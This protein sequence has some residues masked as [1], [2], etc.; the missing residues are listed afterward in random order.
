MMTEEEESKQLLDL[1]ESS[2]G[3]KRLLPHSTASSYLD[4]LQSSYLDQVI[5]EP[6]IVTAEAARLETDITNLCYREYPLFISV[7]QC[8]TAVRNAFNDFDQSLSRLLSSVP[9]LESECKSFADNTLRLQVTR[10]KA[11]LLLEYQDKIGE[12][13]N[14]PR[15]MET[16][17]RNGFYQD[18]IDIADHAHHL[19]QD[20]GSFPLVEDLMS[21]IT[22][23]SQLMT[24]QL[25]N[26]L[27]E[28]IKLPNLMKTVG[29]I[30][31]LNIMPDADLSVVYL[32]SRLYNFER[33]IGELTPSQLDPI[34]FIRR[35]I[36]LFR[37]H[38]YDIITQFTAVFGS[39]AVLES[40][41]TTCV[42]K[43]VQVV[44]DQMPS[45]A[46]D[47]TALS[48]LLVQLG[49]CAMSFSRLGLDFS[50]YFSLPFSDQVLHS[51]KHLLAEANADLAAGFE[52]SMQSHTSLSHHILMADG[53]PAEHYDSH[54][55]EIPPHTSHI[56]PLA[57]FVNAHLS[58]LNQL[59]LLAPQHLSGKLIAIQTDHLASATANTFEFLEQAMSPTEPSRSDTNHRRSISSPRSRLVRQ[60]TET[61]LAPEQRA[62]R[63]KQSWQS[64]M[65]FGRTWLSSMQYLRHAMCHD[66]FQM[67][68]FPAF[69]ELDIF[70]QRLSE[71][72][73]E[74]S[75]SETTAEAETGLLSGS[76]SSLSA[77][78]P[79]GQA[80]SNSTP[81]E[82]YE[83]HVAST[84]EL[85]GRNGEQ[86]IGDRQSLDMPDNLTAVGRVPTP[87]LTGRNGEQSSG[88]RQSLDM[89]DNLTAAGRAPTPEL[90]GRNGEQSIGDRQSL[91]MPDNLTAVGR[92]SS[93]LADSSSHLETLDHNDDN[94]LGDAGLTEPSFE[95]LPTHEPDG[96]ESPTPDFSATD[97]TAIEDAESVVPA[98]G[99]GTAASEPAS[100]ADE[101]PITGPA[102]KKK[103][104][105]K[106]KRP[107]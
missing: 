20:Y 44:L 90:T 1:L 27:R 25:V 36:D 5:Q 94:E 19:F 10:R 58:A 21:E 45:I 91:D 7:H 41:A 82:S 80:V 84:P 66:I 33:H 42:S 9:E 4:Q 34:R 26:L 52:R 87:E 70:Q 88:D 68:D 86:S 22:A 18:A 76:G 92:P 74:R 11:G 15:L 60:N 57:M 55:T 102:T 77:P 29:F 104:K 106:G 46:S 28:T 40:F 24:V 107:A 14:M 67:D 93:M 98:D 49:Y 103:K 13:I 61:L 6:S 95:P 35:Y 59:R 53:P 43:L 65:T 2:S 50:P 71:W 75:G 37:E 17:V 72:T 79:V 62:L 8:S 97:V 96:L 51:F 54:H 3:S 12:L 64:V 101:E 99:T 83:D 30:R 89:P 69:S 78:A 32:S 105:K 31:R 73:L 63:Q 38:V 48:S 39:D 100:Q 56:P 23:V 16:C 81:D 47:P 85:T